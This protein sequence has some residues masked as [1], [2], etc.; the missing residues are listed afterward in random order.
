M[1]NVLCRGWQYRRSFRTCKQAQQMAGTYFVSRKLI[2][3]TILIAFEPNERQYL[4]LYVSEFF[5]ICILLI[6]LELSFWGLITA[7]HNKYLEHCVCNILLYCSLMSEIL[8]TDWRFLPIF[9]VPHFLYSTAYL[10]YSSHML[11]N[12]E[13]NVGNICNYFKCSKELGELMSSPRCWPWHHTNVKFLHESSHLQNYFLE[14]FLTFKRLF[15]S[16]IGH[17]PMPTEQNYNMDFDRNM[18][19]NFYIIQS[20]LLS[21]T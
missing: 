17:C 18:N 20:L 12:R 9:K 13:K 7:W 4:R 11:I 5:R 14:W 3:T 10:H 15:E 1:F 2:I 19:L 6:T 21:S 16:I 8:H